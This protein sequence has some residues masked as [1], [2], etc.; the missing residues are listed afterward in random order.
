MLENV[1]KSLP[2]DSYRVCCMSMCVSNEMNFLSM[3]C[4][5]IFTFGFL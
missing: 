4:Q 2:L 3:K 1:R 5:R